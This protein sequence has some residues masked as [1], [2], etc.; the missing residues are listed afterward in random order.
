MSGH[1][2]P[3]SALGTLKRNALMFG[4]FMIMG[5]VVMELALPWFSIFDTLGFLIGVFIEYPALLAG[6]LVVVV[7]FAIA[8]W[9]QD[10]VGR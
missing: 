3:S 9:V 4:I 5:A 6:V 8:A 2:R 10:N 7:A 1:P